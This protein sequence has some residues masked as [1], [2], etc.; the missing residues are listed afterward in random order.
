MAP[1]RII[2]PLLLAVGL[3]L[4]GP[5]PV[6]AESAYD[7]GRMAPAV[8]SERLQMRVL[9]RALTAGASPAVQ[10]DALKR[11]LV[12]QGHYL[13][14][15]G[16]GVVYR[17]ISVRPVLAYDPNLNGG[18]WKDR[19]DLGW[20]VLWTDPA[21]QARAGWTLGAEVAAELRLAYGPGRFLQVAGQIGAAHAPEQDLTT[22]QARLSVCSRN[23]LAGWTFL[24]ACL[25]QGRAKRSLGTSTSPTGRVAVS[26]IFGLAGGQHEVAFGINRAK[27]SRV[28]QNSADLALESVWNRVVTRFGVTLGQ[29]LATTASEVARIEADL[30]WLANGRKIGV[31][32]WVGQTNETRFLGMRREDTAYGVSLTRDLA[33]GFSLKLEATK[34]RSTVDFFDVTHVSVGLGRTY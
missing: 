29:D 13:D 2:G 11:V 14:G 32:L 4:C 10:T 8:T 33:Q 19:I 31:G 9:G 1:R 3:G 7:L 12:R 16:V 21:M 17:D 25:A 5:A 30:R 26:H 18:V 20:I 27:R 15:G 23:H 28:V 24:D 22:A 6:V 34:T